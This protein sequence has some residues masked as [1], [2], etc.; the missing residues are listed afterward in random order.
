[1]YA[2]LIIKITLYTLPD[3]LVDFLPTVLH[4][5]TVRMHILYNCR[6]LLSSYSNL[7]SSNGLLVLVNKVEKPERL[8]LLYDAIGEWPNYM[9]ATH[10]VHPN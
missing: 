4:C 1:M 6:S 10:S 8:K 9:R 7:C 2:L 3:L 5:I